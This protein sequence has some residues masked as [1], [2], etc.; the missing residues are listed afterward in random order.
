MTVRD[1]SR[2]AYERNRPRAGTDRDAVLRVLEEFGPMFDNLICHKLQLA[3][4]KKARHERRKRQWTINCITPRRGELVE[5]DS[6]ECLG[7]YMVKWEGVNIKALVWRA[8]YN[9]DGEKETRTAEDCGWKKAEGSNVL[10]SPSPQ[11]RLAMHQRAERVREEA[12]KPILK[13]LM[14]YGPDGRRKVT[15]STGQLLLCEP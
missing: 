15:K 11:H 8:K 5:L 4:K 3:D 2:E 9:S 10:P 6:V 12:C 1:T 13:R 14:E 7:E